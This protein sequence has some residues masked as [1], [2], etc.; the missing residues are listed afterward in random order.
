MN[1][2]NFVRESNSLTS[3]SN[4]YSFF[5]ELSKELAARSKVPEWVTALQRSLPKDMH[6]MT[7][8]NIAI[9]ALQPESQFAKAYQN[10]VNKAKYW[11]TTYEDTITLIAKL[12]GIASTIY[13]H[14]YKDGKLIPSDPSLDWS[15][16]F[17]QM[18]GYKD[19]NFNELLRLYL[20]I[21]SDHEGMFYYFLS[22]LELNNSL[23]QFSSL[24]FRRKC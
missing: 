21:H 12:P 14:S 18:L 22:I 17:A 19:P 2:A 9:N 15:A 4:S 16:N 7:Q 6:P 5:L 10:G 3:R 23:V 20:T 1:F 11:E 24:N 13:R 8:F